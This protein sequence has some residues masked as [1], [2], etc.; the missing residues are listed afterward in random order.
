MGRRE[1][2]P[3]QTKLQKSLTVIDR[4]VMALL[5]LLAAAYIYLGVAN[6]QQPSARASR[7]TALQPPQRPVAASSTSRTP[8]SI[9]PPT[10]TPTPS[11]TPLVPQ[12]EPGDWPGYL[13]GNNSY[14]PE[15][16]RI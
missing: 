10:L 4:L 3:D 15:E 13:M 5:V 14:N 7:R 12:I 11:P 1:K 2:K 6:G 8:T 16:V 9:A